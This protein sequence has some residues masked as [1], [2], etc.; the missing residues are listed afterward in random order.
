MHT[1]NKQKYT[2]MYIYLHT[3]YNT[4]IYTYNTH[5]P[6]THTHAILTIGRISFNLT[7]LKFDI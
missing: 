5:I 2:Y 1:R 6:T 4:H 7:L 3:S